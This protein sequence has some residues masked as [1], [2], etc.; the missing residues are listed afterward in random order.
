VY[1]WREAFVEMC[2]KFNISPSHACIRFGMS[3][4]AVSSVALNTSNPGHVKR[5][6]EEVE[7]EITSVFFDAMKE[8]NLIDRDYPFI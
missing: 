2:E 3:H 5:N 8:K 7:N 6:V 4:P 1:K